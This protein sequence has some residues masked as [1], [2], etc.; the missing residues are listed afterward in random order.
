[1]V[2]LLL[3]LFRNIWQCSL[4]NVVKAASFSKIKVLDDSKL[5]LVYMTGA[6]IN[7]GYLVDWKKN[8]RQMAKEQGGKQ[9]PYT[10][11]ST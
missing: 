7:V 10:S 9:A 4:S 2:V 8:N 5:Q 1:M 11:T 3:N 6:H